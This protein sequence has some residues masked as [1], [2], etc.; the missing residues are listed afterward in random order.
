[1]FGV[2]APDFLERS[3]P[4]IHRTHRVRLVDQRE[5]LPLRAAPRQLERVADHPL[6]ALAGEDDLLRCDLVGRALLEEAAH[7]GVG[8]LG[9][10][11]HHHEVHVLGRLSL[12]GHRCSA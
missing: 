9:V 7:A 12:S 3:R 4:Q 8:V 5:L 11:A 1:M 10:L 6:D 2:L